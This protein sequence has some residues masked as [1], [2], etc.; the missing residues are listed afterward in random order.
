MRIVIVGTGTD[1]GKTHVTA[2]LLAHAVRSGVRALGYKPV[3]T[4]VVGRCDDAEA[5]ASASGAPYLHPTFAYRRPVSPHLAAREEGRAVDLAAIVSV[6]GSLRGDAVLVETAGGL[7]SPLG[8][9]TTNADLVRALAPA[10]ALLVAPDRIGVLHD[11][12]AT[13]LAAASLG[14][15]APVVVLSSP[16][17]ADASTGANAEELARLGRAT[18][19]AVFPRASLADPATHAAAALAWGA[20]ATDRAL[21]NG[22]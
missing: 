4:G 18:V 17:V 6:A 11:V 3:A 2:A 8:E 15:P 1:V 19:T 5:H 13:L 20:L 16:A 21:S 10:R 22:R 9:S 12:T 14:L 7:L